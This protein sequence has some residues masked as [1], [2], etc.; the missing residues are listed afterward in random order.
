[1]KRRAFTLLEALVTMALVATVFGTLVVLLQDSSRVVNLSNQ[2]D[3]ARSAGQVGLERVCNELWEATAVDSPAA[4]G[5]DAT[6]LTFEKADP[7][8]TT[9]LPTPIPEP[10]GAFNV[11]DPAFH[12][13]VSYELSGRRFI[14]S[15]G[16][17]GGTPTIRMEVAENVAGFTC[18]QFGRG[19]YYLKLTVEVG[20]N[21]YSYYSTVSC[22]GLE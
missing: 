6:I 9:R 11:A 5:V 7:S 10:P 15:V 13:T 3:A 19:Q 18:T 20:T 2:K 1:M 4:A 12:L 16:P 22:P 14:R 17:R 8:A 21:L